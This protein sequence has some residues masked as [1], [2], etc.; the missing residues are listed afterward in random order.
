MP[1]ILG[2]V[3]TFS[4]ALLVI[5]GD[6]LLKIA[7]DTDQ[8]IASPLVA[9]GC[10]LYAVSAIAWFYALRH[11][12]LSQAGVAYSVLT[13]LALCAIGVLFFGEKLYFREYAGIGCAILAM[14][15]MMRVA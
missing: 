6:V 3:F 12:T 7:A 1:L 11:V 10:A 2:L 4:T 13:L 5:Y 14:F 15:L 8:A 9:A